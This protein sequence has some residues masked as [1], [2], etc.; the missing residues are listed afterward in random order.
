MRVL[1]PIEPVLETMTSVTS[2]SGLLCD[3]KFGKKIHGYVPVHN[4]LI[5][6]CYSTSGDLGKTERIF[7]GLDSKDCSK[8]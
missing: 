1:P 8:W 4:S 2:A 7:L 3:R 5:Q 6:M